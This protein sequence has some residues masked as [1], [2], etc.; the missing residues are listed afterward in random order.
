[1]IVMNGKSTV[2][3]ASV[4]D[5]EA[6]IGGLCGNCAHLQTCAYANPVNDTWFCEEYLVERSEAAGPLPE[7][8]VVLQDATSLRTG[9]CVNCE[10]R[11][12]CT[13]PPAPGGVWFCGEYR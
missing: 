13:F 7:P 4:R 10:L 3:A 1:M 2:K 6:N 9:L 11:E 5:R 8:L 12:S